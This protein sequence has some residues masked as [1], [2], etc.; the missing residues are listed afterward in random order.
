MKQIPSQ[1][2]LEKLME[3]AGKSGQ[4]LRLL[5]DGMYEEAIKIYEQLNGI[6]LTP[7]NLL[8]LSRAYVGA[9]RIVDGILSLEKCVEMEP[10]NS[11]YAEELAKLKNNGRV[12]IV[13]YGV[14]N[15]LHGA[16]ESLCES[17]LQVNQDLVD[18]DMVMLIYA[19]ALAQMDIAKADVVQ[20]LHSILKQIAARYPINCRIFG[21]MADIE[22]GLEYLKGNNIAAYDLL[23][24]AEQNLVQLGDTALTMSVRNRLGLAALH[25]G[26]HKEAIDTF[27]SVCEYLNK[28]GES[29]NSALVLENLADA[30]RRNG[31]FVEALESAEKAERQYSNLGMMDYALKARSLQAKSLADMGN[32]HQALDIIEEVITKGYDIWKDKPTHLADS[33]ITKSYLLEDMQRY[34][35]ATRASLEAEAIYQEMG[36]GDE[37][38]PTHKHSDVGIRAAIHDFSGAEQELLDLIQRFDKSGMVLDAA[39]EKMNLAKLY[40]DEG[41]AYSQPGGGFGNDSRRARIMMSNYTQAGSLLRECIET[42]TRTNNTPLV[43]RARKQLVGL[44]ATQLHT[45][46]NILGLDSNYSERE[47]MISA[48]YDDLIELA[49]RVGFQIASLQQ[50]KAVFLIQIGRPDQAIPVLQTASVI[51]KREDD[52]ACLLYIQKTL[53]EAYELLGNRLLALDAYQVCISLYEKLEARVEGEKFLIEWS[54]DVATFF[55]PVVKVQIELGRYR[56]AY[57]TVMAAKGRNYYFHLAQLRNHELATKLPSISQLCQALTITDKRT[58]E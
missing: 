13:K 11:E 28:T 32:T 3:F 34:A 38:L 20:A 54:K 47:Q 43:I 29:R 49:Q 6:F 33:L 15:L 27:T 56:E 12:L 14:R 1:L 26:R 9:G 18:E 30:Y 21:M 42:F 10:K 48:E 39:R 45:E 35:E 17:L 2:T 40:V 44:L 24:V 23:Q 19:N 57:E 53:G 46:R 31:D 41:V 50:N 8:F 58:Q 22:G 4:A 55:D 51:A 37:I 5:H 7:P 25:L 16:P 52:L 36:V